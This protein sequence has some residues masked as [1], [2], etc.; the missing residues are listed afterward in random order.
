M[1]SYRK[2]K[3]GWKVTVSQRDSSGKLKQKSK[4][5]FSSKLEARAWAAK[6]EAEKDGVL[7]AKRDIPFSEYFKDWVQAYRLP[8]VRAG[9]ASNYRR[10]IRMIRK[11]FGDELISSITR[12][13]YQ[14]YLNSLGKRYCKRWVHQVNATVRSCV[15]A[16][17]YDDYITKD[18]THAVIL[19]GREARKVEYLSVEELHRLTRHVTNAAHPDNPGDYAIL[20]AI[21]TGMRIGEILALKWSDIDRDA[22]VIHVRRSYEQISRSLGPTKTPTSVRDIPT[23]HKLLDKLEDL[24]VPGQEEYLFLRDG[25]AAIY[26]PAVRLLSQRM[27]EVGIEKSGFHF[28][29][30]RH[31]HVAY[32]LYQGVDIYTVSKRLGHAKTSTTIDVY[33]YL[34]AELEAKSN[35]QI[36]KMLDDL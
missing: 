8:A 33:A 9:T 5:G 15:Q 11:E 17:I 2:L 21:Y 22:G 23:T 14:D 3:N 4:Q 35:A 12:D 26:R 25:K 16:A 18:F 29:S 24:R 10:M 27:H 28:H 36:V 6:I 19:T 7:K 34:I 1:A 13:R 30:L 20:I 32:L 31:T